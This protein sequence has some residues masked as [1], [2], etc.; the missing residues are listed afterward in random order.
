MP[1]TLIEP[2]PAERSKTPNGFAGFSR[3][4]TTAKPVAVRHSKSL[5][6]DNNESQAKTVLIAEGRT[7]KM[8]LKT[9]D[10][11]KP[12]KNDE[13]AQDSP[14]SDEFDLKWQ[15]VSDP[16]S[17]GTP[18]PVA[19]I[20]PSD[21]DAKGTIKT[22]DSVP[23]VKHWD[24]DEIFTYFLGTTTAEYAHVF[25]EHEIDGDALLLINR[26][27][28]LTKLNLK[29]GPA[30][31]LYSHILTLQYKNNNPILGWDED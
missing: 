15:D 5:L 28:V 30:L 29:L 13:K 24:C 2:P 7:A 17:A 12:N 14:H 10:P 18:V 9:P 31:R 23:D 11:E 27:D 19:K 20:T 3:E 22:H 8:P 21:F 26:E 16:D 4:D 6:I 25:K 1:P